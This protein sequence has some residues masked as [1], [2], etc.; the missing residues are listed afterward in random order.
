MLA[1]WLL[2][3]PLRNASIVDI[4]WGL[5][6][7]I[8]AF[9]S[10]VLADGFAG[11]RI[12]VTALVTIWGLRLSLHILLR[13]FGKGEDYRY[14]AW[15]EAAG[16]AF[17]WTSFYRVFLVQ[18]VILWIVSMPILAA[19][20]YHSPGHFTPID[21]AGVLV[22][23]VGFTFEAVGDIQ[24]ARFKAS[25]GNKGKVMRTGLW[26]FTRHPN[27]FGD[28]AVW[29]G[30]FLVAAATISG[31][32]T[33]F[34]PALM[35]FLLVRVSGVALLEKKQVETRPEYRDYI[36]STSAFIPWLP[37]QRSSG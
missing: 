7:V 30:L 37:K 5:G 26:R 15:R 14:R 8:V 31:L 34:S 35:T 33:I 16:P 6:F 21:V 17:W 1:I 4:F 10:L 20:Y 32:W 18:G 29:W 12:L 2:S 3:L 22:W 24:L 36:E 9:L 27:Y 13:N 23:C 28:A 19:G 11:R 25:P